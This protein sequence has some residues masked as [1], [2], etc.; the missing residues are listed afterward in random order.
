MMKKC[1]LVLVIAAVVAG[2]AFAQNNNIIT[3]DIGPTI[4]GAWIKQFTDL[5][6]L[7]DKSASSSGFGIGLQYERRL[8]EKLCLTGRASYL[9]GGI[10]YKVSDVLVK[11]QIDSFSLEAHARFYPSGRAFF[12]DGMLG[13]AW[14]G[15]TFGGD[16]KITDENGN[17]TTVNVISE[18]IPRNYFKLGAKLG[19]RIDF[20]D[21]GGF[22]FEPAF[23]WSYAV[24]IGDTIGTKL[25]KKAGG[26]EDDATTIDDLFFLLERFGV[27]GFRLCLSFGYRF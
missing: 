1:L 21:E 4:A 12:L 18:T 9:G 10:G 5:I 27:G 15:L 3:V 14:M 24:G 11:M 6:K 17:K 23:G 13:Y 20:G 2:G 19:W 26:N 25:M 22:I 8:F 7:G 16:L